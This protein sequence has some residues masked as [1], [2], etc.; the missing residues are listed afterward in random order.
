MRYYLPI[1]TLTLNLLAVASNAN[2]QSAF[3]PGRILVTFSQ[4]QTE[5]GATTKI[6]KFGKLTAIKKLKLLADGEIAVVE[7]A[8]GKEKA[9]VANLEKNKSQTSQILSSELD[10]RI[11][12]DLLPNDPSFPSQWHLQTVKAAPAWDKTQGSPAIIVAILDSGVDASHPELSS[13]IVPGWNL[14]DNNSNTS[15]VM[16]H[17]TKVA[18]SAV[19]VSNNGD[20]IASLCWNCGIM[21]IRVSDLAGYT[22]YSTL[23]SGLDYARSKG[24]RVANMSFQAYPS[25]AVIT[26]AK[27]FQQAGG[28][29]T[30]SAGNGGDNNLTAAQTSAVVVSATNSA[31]LKTSW[32]TYGTPVTVS[33]PG[34]GILTTTSGGG[35]G[36]VSGTSF[37]APITAGVAALVLSANP[38]LTGVQARQV[39]IDSADDLGTSGW[40]ELF[41]Y[42]R[43][44]AERA[45]Q[46][47]GGVLTDSTPPQVAFTSPSASSVL[48]G[49]VSVN[50]DASDN[51]AV[52]SV[53]FYVDG[54][55]R[56]TDSA[57]PFTFSWNTIGATNGS[58]T[59]DAVAQDSSA[60]TNSTSISVSV[61]NLSDTTAPT[62]FIT[63]PTEGSS[64][65]RNVTITGSY[66]DNLAVTRVELFIDGT[67]T[68]SSSTAPFN[69]KWSSGKASRGNH[70][71]RT[72][73]FDA[74]GNGSSSQTITITK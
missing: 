15:D 39:L 38:R 32:S 17:G 14:F 30:I 34:E 9:T 25:F 57:A 40:D 28:V 67:K 56:A 74:A 51:V 43:V 69:L 65:S 29:V 42:G 61:L 31:D 44:N 5:S 12:P 21:P 8:K 7:I 55:L 47:A 73:A 33:A 22:Y 18:G 41:G 4:S 45:V 10:Q 19:A 20:G 71:I 62:A 1:L 6:K 37:A 50:A 36:A 2:A 11:A 66:S 68:T 27:A 16:G 53:S 59:L 60:N 48:A 72:V 63:S 3:A 46:L 52:S 64:I 13:R 58:H 26:A 24:A 54:S 23:A 49:T 70:T 35:Y